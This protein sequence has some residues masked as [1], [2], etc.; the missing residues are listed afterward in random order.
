MRAL[1]V[2]DDEALQEFYG[3]LLMRAGYAVTHADSASE[4]IE[5]LE[6]SYTLPE[7]IFLDIR[8]PG[9]SGFAVLDFLEDHPHGDFTHVA[10]VTAGSEFEPTV[11]QFPF[12]SFHLKP[13][14]PAKILEIAEA[15]KQRQRP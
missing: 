2:E 3:Y 10:V 8:M 1:T 13:I 15:V 7:L 11:R 14:L 4:A 6:Q 9:G 12:A 5:I